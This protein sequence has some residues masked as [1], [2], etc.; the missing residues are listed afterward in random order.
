MN[1]SAL[2]VNKCNRRQAQENTYVKDTSDWL[3]K[4]RGFQT[5]HTTWVSNTTANTRQNHSNTV[6]SVFCAFEVCF[7]RQNLNEISNKNILI[8]HFIQFS[9]QVNF[10][11]MRHTRFFGYFLGH[12][13]S[14]VRRVLLNNIINSFS[15]YLYIY[16]FL[17]IYLVIYL[18]IYLF[19]DSHPET[20]SASNSS[21]CIFLPHTN[22]VCSR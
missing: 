21:L 12:V 2:E 8:T 13:F 15:F 6:K 1:Q 5:K 17:F 4:W 18:F 19:V 11:Y 10:H 20:T 14:H 7:L 16:F 9:F 3:R 22:F